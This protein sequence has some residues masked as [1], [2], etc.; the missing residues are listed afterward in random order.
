MNLRHR[1]CSEHLLWKEG[2]IIL[3]KEQGGADAAFYGPRPFGII[4]LAPFQTQA[5]GLRKESL[6]TV[7]K[8][9]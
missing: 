4:H 3:M 9:E 5:L 8:C 1:R 7:I 6:K 2:I